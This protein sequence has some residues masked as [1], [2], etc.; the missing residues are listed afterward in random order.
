MPNTNPNV[1]P[2]QKDRCPDKPFEDFSSDR[3]VRGC[4]YAGRYLVTETGSIFTMG[5]KGGSRFHRQ[6]PR[7]NGKGYLRAT[8]DRHDEYI[9]RIVAKCFI[10]NPNGYN[11]INHRDGNKTNNEASNLEWC[12]RSE[13]NRHAF[14]TGLRDYRELSVLARMPKI[15]RRLFNFD[16]VKDICKMLSAGFSARV[17]ARKYHCSH[18]AIYSIQYKKSYRDFLEKLG[19]LE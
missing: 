7:T 3:R 18:G 4:I 14:Q 10:P 15:K 19:M 17:I 11:E 12:T 16:Q 5:I 1:S 6:I 2:K 13:N 8:I 9:H